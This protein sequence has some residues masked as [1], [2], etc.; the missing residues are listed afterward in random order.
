MSQESATNQAFSHVQ[1]LKVGSVGHERAVARASVSAH[2]WWADV[3]S[4]PDRA[5]PRGFLGWVNVSTL[6]LSLDAA[7]KAFPGI[8]GGDRRGELHARQPRGSAARETR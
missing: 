1:Q 3:L 4:M 5:T 2:G 6:G 8:R 7:K